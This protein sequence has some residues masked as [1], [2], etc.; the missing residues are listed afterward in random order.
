M[1]S[2][3][4]AFTKLRWGC[5]GAFL[6]ADLVALNKP[7]VGETFELDFN[8][9]TVNALSGL[10]ISA[11]DGIDASGC[12][13]DVA[14]LGEV[15]LSLASTPKMFFLAPGQTLGQFPIPNDHNLIGLE[16]FAQ[17]F[18]LD[19]GFTPE[20]IRLSASLLIHFGL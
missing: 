20:P 19:P 15:H 18:F 7:G 2:K 1:A 6:G 10:A 5:K 4:F 9:H 16:L 14:G 3:H 12:G 11:Q 8:P 17:A 13:F